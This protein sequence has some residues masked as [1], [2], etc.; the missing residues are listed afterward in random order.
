MPNNTLILPRSL[1]V[2]GTDLLLSKGAEEFDPDSMVDEVDS[3][4]PTL[5]QPQSV[6]PLLSLILVNETSLE[7]FEVGGLLQTVVVTKN[8][9]FSLGFT[10]LLPVAV[11]ISSMVFRNRIFLGSATVK[12]ESMENAWDVPEQM[13]L[14]N[15]TIGN[16]VGSTAIVTLLFARSEVPG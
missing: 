4:D 10:C 3:V 6:S 15:V 16:F 2:R 14:T 11:E 13:A 5:A 9:L 7:P 8:N 1:S 12:T